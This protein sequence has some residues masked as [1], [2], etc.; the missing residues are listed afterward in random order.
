MKSS[1]NWMQRS[2]YSFKIFIEIYILI[3]LLLISMSPDF[4]K[5]TKSNYGWLPIWQSLAIINQTISRSLSMISAFFSNDEFLL[6]VY[7]STIN[8]EIFYNFI[9]IIKYWCRS[10]N[11]DIKEKIIV[12]F[13]NASYYSWKQTVEFFKLIK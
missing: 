11:I 13:D 12:V 6:S 5:D 7:K 1:L 8:A 10:N 4:N 3:N 9:S 2:I